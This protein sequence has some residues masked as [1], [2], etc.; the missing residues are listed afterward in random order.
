MVFHDQYDSQL[1]TEEE[2]AKAKKYELKRN[3]T[4]SDSKSKQN[5]W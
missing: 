3:M 5:K 4:Q 2:V 1:A